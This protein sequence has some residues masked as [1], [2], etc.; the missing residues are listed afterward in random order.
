M[1]RGGHL[2][3]AGYAYPHNAVDDHARSAYSEIPTDEKEESAAV[4]R[5][6]AHTSPPRVESS[7]QRILRAPDRPG[8]RRHP[9]G[10]RQL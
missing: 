2:S 5:Q 9:A 8:R 10:V 4:F 6:R 1:P 7:A 3:G